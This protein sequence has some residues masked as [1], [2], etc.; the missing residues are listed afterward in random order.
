M[1]HTRKREKKSVKSVQG[2]RIALEHMREFAQAL[3][4]KDG[5]MTSK[6]KEFQSEWRKTFHRKLDD[7]AAKSYLA[8][9]AK[10]PGSGSGQKG[11][12][13]PL[14]YEMR[15]GVEGVYGQY[16][17]YISSGLDAGLGYHNSQLD[18]CGKVDTTPSGANTTA[19]GSVSQNTA[20][21]QLGGRTRRHSRRSSGRKQ[22]GGRAFLSSMIQRPFETGTPT[23]IL[24]DGMASWKGLP[25]AA[26]PDASQPSFNF[27]SGKDMPA[28]PGINVSVITRP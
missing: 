23:S 13:A 28:I 24:Y 15:P 18:L 6:V 4:K 27:V 2:L 20:P 8:F 9:I 17:A 11:G 19:Y 10:M 14:N 3:N 7:S 16:P 26:S 22:N 25:P 12:M 1:R 21:Q 5:L